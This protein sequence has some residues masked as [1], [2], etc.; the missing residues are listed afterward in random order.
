M[1]PAEGY[2]RT[3]TG[4]YRRCEFVASA[5]RI[6]NAA[7]FRCLSL[8]PLEE[9]RHCAGRGGPASQHS[10]PNFR[11]EGSVLAGTNLAAKQGVKL[12]CNLTTSQQRA[13]RRIS[14]NLS[15]RRVRTSVDRDGR[16]GRDA[17]TGSRDYPATV[18]TSFPV[19]DPSSM[20]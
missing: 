15:R 7:T 11:L 8:R 17:V 16:Q 14:A 1:A 18:T 5:L 2:S 12:S 9:F 10:L 3:F 13:E 6:R 20:S 4:L 19:I